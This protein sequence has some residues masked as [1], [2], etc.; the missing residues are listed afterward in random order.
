MKVKKVKKAEPDPD[1]IPLVNGN[2]AFLTFYKSN[3]S[4]YLNGTEYTTFPKYLFKY[5]K[6]G[7]DAKTNKDILVRITNASTKGLYG[8]YVKLTPENRK[9]YF[10]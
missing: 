2:N 6:R 1:K 9:A 8:A 4:K 3:V 5:I 7:G 10:T